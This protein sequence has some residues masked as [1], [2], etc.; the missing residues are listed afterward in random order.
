MGLFGRKKPK[1]IFVSNNKLIEVVEVEHSSTTIF[2]LE[3]EVEKRKLYR[4]VEKINFVWSTGTPFVLV[5]YKD[6]KVRSDEEVKKIREALYKE[7][8]IEIK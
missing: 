6:L 1:P 7:A 8:G 3:D 5:E 2:D 4:N